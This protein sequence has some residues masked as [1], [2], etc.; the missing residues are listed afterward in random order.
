MQALIRVEQNPDSREGYQLLGFTWLEVLWVEPWALAVPDKEWGPWCDRRVAVQYVCMTETGIVRISAEDFWVA[1]EE[2]EEYV[3]HHSKDSVEAPLQIV[4][5]AGSVV[6]VGNS[7]S[8]SFNAIGNSPQARI[9]Q[10]QG[11]DL[12]VLAFQLRSLR[13]ALSTGNDRE[14]QRKTGILAEAEE[15]AERGDVDDAIAALRRGGRWLI[16]AA[17]RLGFGLLEEF[18]KRQVGLGS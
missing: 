2:Y 8:S 4:A 1:I 16:E 5:G 10:T 18:V 3:A 7:S 17:D 14:T 9:E 6:H 11:V 12:D 13:E 15:A